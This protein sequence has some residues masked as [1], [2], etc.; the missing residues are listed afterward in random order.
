MLQS[1]A[2]GQVQH[3]FSAQPGRQ[4]HRGCRQAELG[5]G[6]AT[7]QSPLSLYEG[8]VPTYL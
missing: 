2:S 6:G 7:E 8:E 3:G 1:R 4:F 5:G